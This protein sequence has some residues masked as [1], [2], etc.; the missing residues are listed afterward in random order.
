MN[1]DNGT[2]STNGTKRAITLKTINWAKAHDWYHSAELSSE[3]ELV[4]YCTD[5][6]LGFEPK[7]RIIVS[8][9]CADE[10]KAWAGY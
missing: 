5:Y 4:I 1:K 8:F 3:D 7:K 6:D 10:L 2:N 9:T